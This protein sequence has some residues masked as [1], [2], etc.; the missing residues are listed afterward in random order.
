VIADVT[1]RAAAAGDAAFIGEMLAEAASW[2]RPPGDPAPPLADLLVYPCIADYVDGWGRDG[3]HGLIA[4]AVG[5]PAGACWMRR[6]SAEHP[7]YGYLGTDIPGIGLA[8]VPG[9]RGRGIGRRLLEGLIE[10][11]RALDVGAVSLSVAERNAVARALYERCGFV[12]VDREGD[13]L[14]MRL[15][16]AADPA[17]TPR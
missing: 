15:D 2:D 14:T 5:R 13:S 3:D 8:V 16:L 17:G 10:I 11:A 7:G 12:V 6:Y 1:L 4:E 9:S